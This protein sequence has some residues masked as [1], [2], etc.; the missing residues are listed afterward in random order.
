MS[1]QQKRIWSAEAA[2]A[3]LAVNAPIDDYDFV[4]AHQFAAF[5]NEYQMQGGLMTVAA[6]KRLLSSQVG[7]DE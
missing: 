5:S 4:E 7:A 6:F 1:T 2:R 3:A